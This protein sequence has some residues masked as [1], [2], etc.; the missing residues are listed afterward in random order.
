MIDCRDC[1]PCPAD[2]QKYM[3][4]WRL[5]CGKAAAGAESA[6]GEAF[7]D[8]SKNGF[9]NSQFLLFLN[10]IKRQLKQEHTDAWFLKTSVFA[11]KNI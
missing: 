6:L 4:F 1:V 11:F 9:S 5:C 3:R 7:R 2:A 10:L 8:L